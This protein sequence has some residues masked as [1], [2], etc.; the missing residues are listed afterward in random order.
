MNLRG[1]PY[2]IEYMDITQLD[3]SNS[4]DTLLLLSC[5]VGHQHV[6]PNMVDQLISKSSSNIKQIIAPDGTHYRKA[7]WIFFKEISVKGDATWKSYCPDDTEYVSKGFV[8][9]LRNSE[10][11]YDITSIGKSFKSVKRLLNKLK[12]LTGDD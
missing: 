6:S 12:E 8:R 1:S 4:I 3:F 5:N 10:G 7:I 9:Y 2:G 11:G